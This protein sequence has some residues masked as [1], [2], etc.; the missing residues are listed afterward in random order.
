[1]S[2][3]AYSLQDFQVVEKHIRK[4]IGKYTHAFHGDVGDLLH[5]DICVVDPTPK[6]NYITLV[7][8][9][10][11]AYKMNVKSDETRLFNR[12]ELLMMLPPTWKIDDPK[13]EWQWPA[14]LLADLS[15]YPMQHDTWFDDNF[16]M[17]FNENFGN[18][19]FSSIMIGLPIPFGRKSF[20]G[21]LF[22][23]GEGVM[24]YQVLPL[25]KEELDKI[26][27]G[28]YNQFKQAAFSELYSPLNIERKNFGLLI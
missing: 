26:L 25:Y 18:T 9:G 14:Q 21:C 22:R 4:R 11:G 15:V 8:Q 16:T 24:F 20:G 7:T 19:G 6:R 27:N 10:M 3:L 2:K 12:I 17:S 13:P 5:L 1:M 28:K 23:Y